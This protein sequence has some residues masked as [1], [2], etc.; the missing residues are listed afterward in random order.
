MLLC[1]IALSQADMADI[2]L[3]FGLQILS[4]GFKDDEGGELNKGCFGHLGPANLLLKRITCL[5]LQDWHLSPV[6]YASI[7]PK[8]RLHLNTEV[9]M[10]ICPWSSSRTFVSK[11]GLEYLLRRY[12]WNPGMILFPIQ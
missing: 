3:G 12:D 9:I 11:M 10:V 7:V 5:L 6:V 8:G 2:N 4:N 1:Q